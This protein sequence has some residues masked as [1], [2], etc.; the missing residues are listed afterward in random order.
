MKMRLRRIG[1]KLIPA[2]RCSRAVFPVYKLEGM[3][4][5]ELLKWLAENNFEVSFK[6][7]FQR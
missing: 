1:E 7:E 5:E 6:H 2:C 4:E 3:E